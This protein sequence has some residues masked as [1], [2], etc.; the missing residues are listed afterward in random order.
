LNIDSFIF[1]R[2]LGTH[3]FLKKQFINIIYQ[4]QQIFNLNVKNYIIFFGHIFDTKMTSNLHKMEKS[5]LF[6]ILFY[7]LIRKLNFCTYIM[8]KLRFNCL[9]PP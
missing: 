6:K 1:N 8:I 5:K 4:F 2:V 3:G 7:N 9:C